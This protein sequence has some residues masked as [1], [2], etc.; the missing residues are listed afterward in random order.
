MRD[1]GF[2]EVKTRGRGLFAFRRVK[3][4]WSFEGFDPSR[5]SYFVFLAMKAFG[6]DYVSL[7][8]IEL[9]T[10]ARLAEEH[11]GR[12]RAASGP[13]MDV[14]AEGGW[15]K[16]AFSG[17]AEQGWAVLVRTPSVSADLR[18]VPAAPAHRNR[19]VTRRIDY[20]ILQFVSCDLTGRLNAGGDDEPFEGFGYCEHNWGVQPRFSASNWLHYWAPGLAGVVLDCF[21]DEGVHHHYNYLW[22]EDEGACLASPTSFGFDP[23]D[24]GSPWRVSSDAIELEIE[25]LAHHRNRIRIPPVVPYLDIDYHEM[26]VQVRG[27]AF[28][29]SE[30]VEIDAIGKYDYNVNRW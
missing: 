26:L 29:H 3:Q 6:V 18:S 9:R 10:G 23:A 2:I 17:S 5:Q 12:V 20:N 27:K 19:L 13:M 16:V 1:E 4:W 15:G 25:P 24:P 7:T 22:R 21:Y 28:V 14:S 8:T 11:F 30:P